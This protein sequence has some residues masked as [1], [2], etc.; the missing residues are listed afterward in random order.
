MK[1]IIVILLTLSSILGLSGCSHDAVLADKENSL[2]LPPEFDVLP[3]ASDNKSKDAAGNEV[4]HDS[5]Q[6]LD[7]KDLKKLKDTLLK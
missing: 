3:D 1:K 5:K 7:Q 2:I 4:N 6:N